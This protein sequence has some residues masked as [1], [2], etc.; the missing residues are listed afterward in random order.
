[1]LQNDLV[2]LMN[3][4]EKNMQIFFKTESEKRSISNP[5][6]KILYDEP[7]SISVTEE[8][9]ENQKINEIKLPFARI[10]IVSPNS[11]AEEAGLKEGDKIVLFDS[12]SYSEK[13]PLKKIAEVVGK[14]INNIINVEIMRK[15]TTKE[16]DEKIQYLNI[17]LKPHTWN[18][19]G[20]LG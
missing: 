10:D 20:V 13:D 6:K 7:I 12:V 8:R 15:Q 17:E 11:P 2:S 3:L 14:K 1:M 4:L 18:G 5:E 16:G 9:K 19:Q